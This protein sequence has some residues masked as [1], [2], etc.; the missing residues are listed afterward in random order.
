M[1]VSDWS[2]DVCAS[3]LQAGAVFA[4]G[5][6]MVGRGHRAPPTAGRP[7]KA[8]SAC[9]ASRKRGRV[10]RKQRPETWRQPA[11]PGCCIAR[12]QCPRR[13]TAHANASEAS[14]ESGKHPQIASPPTAGEGSQEKPNKTRNE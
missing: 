11:T 7:T 14:E 12:R 10:G 5:E 6:L 13:Y 1:R 4:L 8:S 9:A 2:S 3:D